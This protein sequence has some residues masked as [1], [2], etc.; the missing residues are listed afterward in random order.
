[1][2]SLDEFARSK[3]GEAETRALKRSLAETAQGPGQRVRRGGRSL[4]SFCAND[5]L[6]LAQH[7]ALKA[8]AKRALDAYGAGAGASRL[9]TGN[10]PLYAELEAKLAALKHTEAALVFGSGYL[11]NVGVVPALV[12]AGDLILADELAHACLI[13]GARLSGARVV[14]YRHNDVDDLRAHLAHE[15]PAARHC[16][17]LTEGVFSMDGDLAPLSA[18]ADVARAHRAWLMTDDAHGFGVVGNGRGSAAQWGVAPDVQMGTLSKAVGSYGGYVCASRA[19]VDL[20]VTRTRSL[21]YATAL[22]PPVIAAAIA[23]VDIIASDK[24]LCAKPLEY[25]RAFARAAGLAVP[26]SSIVPL[27][28]GSPDAALV[29]SRLLED[30]GFLVVAIRPPTVP[31]GTARLRFSFAADH[32]IEDVLQLAE[33]V[34]T[35][36]LARRAA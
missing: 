18:I 36:I 7:P 32:A 5:Y 30:E 16:L 34:R 4:V 8:A 31:D 9:V 11:A 22:P 13:S 21:I 20:L 29:A 15:R 1:M 17:V 2:S 28:L 23:G 19:V 33:I 27:L 24:A 12:G 14:L 26:E 3:L 25:A 35:R 10:H 6:G